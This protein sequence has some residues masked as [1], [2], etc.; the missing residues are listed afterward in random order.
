MGS[1]QRIPQLLCHGLKREGPVGVA[2][3]RSFSTPRFT[4]DARS[5]KR[6]SVFCFSSPTASQTQSEP[7]ALQR[8]RDH[9]LQLCLCFERNN[10]RELRAMLSDRTQA[11]SALVFAGGGS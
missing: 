4:T 2:R 9:F 5:S 7:F 1:R 10:S 11:K 6:A 8:A 3:S